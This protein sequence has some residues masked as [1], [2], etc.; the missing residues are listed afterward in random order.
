MWSRRGDHF[1]SLRR[2]RRTANWLAAAGNTTRVAELFMPE[3]LHRL[4]DFI[5]A[6]APRSGTTWLYVLAQR[7][8][9]IAMAQP[10]AP[11]PKFFLIDELWQRGIDYYSRTWFDRLP[12]GQ[13]LGEKS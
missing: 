4:P 1:I 3:A 8:P 11:E 9:Q 12:A 2:T 5:I 10:M 7:H 6:G 13:V